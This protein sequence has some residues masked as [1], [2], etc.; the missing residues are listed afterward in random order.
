MG[1]F[2]EHPAQLRERPPGGEHHLDDFKRRNQPVAR[3]GNIRKDNMATRL[4]AQPCALR[5]HTF[6]DITIAH[7]GANHPAARSGNRRID[8]K[9]ALHS[10]HQRGR[11]QTSLG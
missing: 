10:D 4:A 8:A 6:A 11:G 7:G 5:Q 2:L 9:V 1:E 3:R